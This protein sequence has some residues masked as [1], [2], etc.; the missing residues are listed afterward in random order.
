MIIVAIFVLSVSSLVGPVVFFKGLSYF[1]GDEADA[2]IVGKRYI[3][4]GAGIL[5][6]GW[7]LVGLLLLSVM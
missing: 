5:G 3:R 1:N 6:G 4:I 2:D 7:L